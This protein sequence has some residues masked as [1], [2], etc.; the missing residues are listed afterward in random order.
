MHITYNAHYNIFF[1]SQDINNLI[2]IQSHLQGG[3]GAGEWKLK[4]GGGVAVG[5]GTAGSVVV[6]WS[7]ASVYEVLRK[8]N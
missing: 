7:V 4:N 8:C 5:G 3:W 6:T 1:L 2:S